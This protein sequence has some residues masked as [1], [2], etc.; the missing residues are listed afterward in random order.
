MQLNYCKLIS[1]LSQNK[2]LKSLLMS[3]Y[4]RSCQNKP[5]KLDWHAIK[6]YTTQKTIYFVSSLKLHKFLV[7]SK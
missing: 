4:I 3:K 2:Y 6:Y 5:Y 1:Y 7:T